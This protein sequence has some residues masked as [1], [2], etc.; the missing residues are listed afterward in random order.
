MNTESAL[1]IEHLLAALGTKSERNGGLRILH[2]MI[3]ETDARL[4]RSLSEIIREP[5]TIED[6]HRFASLL[7][8]IAADEFI[9]P[10]SQVISGATPNTSPWLT[11]YMYA[12][13][14][15]LMEREDLWPAEENFVHLLGHWLFSTGGGEISWKSGVIL[16]HLEHPATHPYFLRGAREANLFCETRIACI[17]G[18][19]NQ[20][21]SEAN[22]LL[23][24]LIADPD[25]HVRES[26]AKALQWLEE[27][28][29]Q[30][31]D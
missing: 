16:A 7:A 4:V 15:L 17:H 3:V 10:L 20:Y 2:D 12:L 13:G 8:T 18:I 5:E 27:Q 26:V 1:T 6:P 21:R 14:T 25:K 30:K 28:S 31:T 11:S 19:I 22:S 29:G 23:Q 9:P 24:E